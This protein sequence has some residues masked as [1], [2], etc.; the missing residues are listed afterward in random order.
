M[1]DLDRRRLSIQLADLQGEHM[2]GLL[3]LIQDDL[4][5][6]QPG[7]PDDE[8]ELDL[9]ALPVSTLLKMQAFVN[10]VA[11]GRSNAAVL[12][13]PPSKAAPPPASA[14]A[15]AGGGQQQHLG[16][17]QGQGHTG[18]PAV[19]GQALAGH[20]SPQQPAQA[21][22]PPD[23]D[24][25]TTNAGSSGAPGGVAVCVVCVSVRLPPSAGQEPSLAA[26]AVVAGTAR[27]ARRPLQ[28]TLLRVRACVW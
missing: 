25:A 9:D 13:A 19:P 12:M 7:A 21:A 5:P 8:V 1:S 27:D 3:M 11:A 15:A 26:A 17:G 18:A 14:A 28:P 24:G 16:G 4:P 10:S 23:E 20:A 6:P 22:E 2:N